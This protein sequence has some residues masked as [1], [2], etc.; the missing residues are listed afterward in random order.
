MRSSQSVRRRSPASS[1]HE[2]Q[3]RV[4]D[5]HSDRQCRNL[6]TIPHPAAGLL[7]DLLATIIRTGCPFAFINT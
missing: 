6:W 7:F 4:C 1:A 3:R 5:L 2:A